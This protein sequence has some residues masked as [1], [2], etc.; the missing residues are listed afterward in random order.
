MI[1]ILIYDTE[2]SHHNGV[3]STIEHYA[4]V[5]VTF[6][7]MFEGFFGPYD[8]TIHQYCL[9]NDIDIVVIPYSGLSLNAGEMLDDGITVIKPLHNTP[10]YYTGAIQVAGGTTQKESPDFTNPGLDFYSECSNLNGDLAIAPSFVCGKVAGLVANLLD[11]GYTTWQARQILRQNCDS[12]DQWTPEEG[13][14]KLPDT[15]T[16]PE[17]ILTMPPVNVS[18]LRNYST[19]LNPGLGVLSFNTESGGGF[20]FGYEGDVLNATHSPFIIEGEDKQYTLTYDTDYGQEFAALEFTLEDYVPKRI[21]KKVELLYYDSTEKRF[22]LGNTTRYKYI[23]TEREGDRIEWRAYNEQDELVK[24]EYSRYL[25]SYVPLDK[26]HSPDFYLD[27]SGNTLTFQFRYVNEY[28]EGEWSDDVVVINDANDRSQVYDFR[29]LPDPDPDP[30]PEEPDPEPPVIINDRKITYKGL[31]L[32]NAQVYYNGELL[33][34]VLNERQQV[35]IELE[36]VKSFE[37]KKR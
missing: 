33:F 21:P 20:V 24:Q 29:N 28:G 12:F 22:C 25:W 6:F 36:N 34:E 14:G 19:S 26:L 37:I 32:Q 4:T 35:D 2:S 5:N 8:R 10:N 11:E 23:K 3:K 17:T 16:I 13:F 18:V 15:I 27:E 1:N 9:D 31:Q 7:R 30:E